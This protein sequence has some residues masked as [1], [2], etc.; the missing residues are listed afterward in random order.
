[1]AKKTTAKKARKSTAKKKTTA[2]KTTA[3]K[4]KGAA[5]KTTAARKPAAKKKIASKKTVAKKSTTIIKEPLTKSQLFTEIAEQ[6]EVAKKDVAAIFESLS[7]VI[8][9]HI[10]KRGVGSFTLPGLAK[11]LVVRKKATK[12]RKGVNPFTGEPTVFKAKPARNVVKI[13]ALKKLK[14]MAE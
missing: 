1:M 3:T 8:E 6:T 2:R 11:V 9:R 4:K 10:G 5:K 12:A 7:E 13:R 14:E